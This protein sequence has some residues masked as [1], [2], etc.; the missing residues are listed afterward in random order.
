MIDFVRLKYLDKEKMEKFITNSDNFKRCYT[1]MEY[2]SGEILYPYNVYLKKMEVSVNEKSVYLKNS[3]HKMAN[4]IEHEEDHNYNDFGY[5]RLCDTIDYLNR[6]VIDSYSARLTQLEFG[7]NINTPIPAEN[8]IENNILFHKHKLHNVDTNFNGKGKYKQFEYSNFYIKIYD[9]AKQY[10]LD[11][12]ILRF[13]IKYKGA[14]GINALGIYNLLNLKDKVVLK[15]LF[16]HLLKRFDEHT[17]IDE[18]TDKVSKKDKKDLI[19]YLSFNY[20]VN[21]SK[22]EN[23]NLKVKH[24]KRFNALLEKNNLL[25]TKNLL[26]KSL[27]KRF[28][29]LLD[30]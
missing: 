1:K 20:W 16:K 27:I 8:I 17:I 23:R 14:K 5:K 7:L 13:E 15:L 28:E 19:N 9:K 26:R 30:N 18:I 21:L 2:H 12:N 29:T 6:K 24:K 22:R 25:H 3:L 4:Y 11:T 10:K